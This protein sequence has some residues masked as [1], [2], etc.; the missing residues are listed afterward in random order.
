MA[1]WG[2]PTVIWPIYGFQSIPIDTTLNE[3]AH[4]CHLKLKVFEIEG[5]QH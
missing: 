3:I 2:H 4:K 5:R 1:K